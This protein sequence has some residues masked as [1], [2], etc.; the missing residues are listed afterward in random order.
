MKNFLAIVVVLSMIISCTP[1]HKTEKIV[2][3]LSVYEYDLTKEVVQL[4]YDA[5]AVIEARGE[6]AFPDFREKDSIWFYGDNYVF[7]WGL[8]GMRY[9]YPPDIS[10]EGKNMLELQ[11]VNGKPIGKMF[12]ETATTGEGW[13]FYEWNLPGSDILEWKSTFIRKAVA[14]SGKEFLVGSGKYNIPVEKIFVENI[15]K[16]A[17]AVLH[18]EGKE[19]AFAR[20]NAITDKFIFL[21][22]YVFVKT[23]AGVE[24]VNPFSPELVGKDIRYLQDANGKYFVRDELELLKANDSC[25]MEYVWPKPGEKEPSQKLVYVEKVDVAGEKLVVGAGYFSR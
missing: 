4:V 17:A 10:G 8:D 20:F 23:D 24:L 16:E 18:K 6:K 22:S 21:D 12:L 25:W 7:V 11:D 19:A 5:V 1:A 14:P 13:V 3:D 2:P 15:V 9:V